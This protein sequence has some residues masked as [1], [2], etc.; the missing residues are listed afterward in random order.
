MELVKHQQGF[1][2]TCSRNWRARFVIEQV[3]QRREVV[4]AEHGAQK[5]S[6]FFSRQQSAF[7]GT[8]RH[9]RKV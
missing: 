9:S 4:T 1:L 5:F 3:N 6:G 2:Q 7:F 8:V